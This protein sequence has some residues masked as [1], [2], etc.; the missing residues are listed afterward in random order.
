M[1]VSKARQREA[2]QLQI[3]HAERSVKTALKRREAGAF[4]AS[5]LGEAEA[6]LARKTAE[7]AEF[8]A[9]N[10]ARKGRQFASGRVQVIV[11][12]GCGKRTTSGVDNTNLELCTACYREASVSNM[13]SDDNHEG[14]AEDCAECNATFERLTGIKGKGR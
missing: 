13:H 8:E 12:A 14:A 2:L 10:P 11:C 3:Q 6:Y 4:R 5:E 1:Y 7:L 9:A